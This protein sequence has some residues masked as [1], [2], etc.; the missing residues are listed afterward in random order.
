MTSRTKDNHFDVCVIGC[1]PAGFAGAMRAVD[2][3]KHVCIV[4]RK[5]IGGAGLMWG[6]LSSKTMWELAKDYYVASRTDRGYRAENLTVHYKSVRKTVFRAVR[7]KQ[8]QMIDQIKALHPQWQRAR[9][10]VEY[11]RGSGSFIDKNTLEVVNAD[12]QSQVISADYFLIAT[13]S[14]PRSRV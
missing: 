9:G 5:Q 3:G 8:R 12:G 7:E 11:R 2:L 6:A 4:E 10:S 13:G 14:S 1:G